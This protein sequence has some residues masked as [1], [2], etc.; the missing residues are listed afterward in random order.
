MFKVT[1]TET[2]ETVFNLRELE[3]HNWPEQAK[4]IAYSI[5]SV[6]KYNEQFKK[7]LFKLDWLVTRVEKLQITMEEF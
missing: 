2:T 6:P 3:F 5:L 1:K 4:D 7:E